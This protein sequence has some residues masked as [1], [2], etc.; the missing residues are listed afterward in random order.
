MYRKA[1]IRALTGIA[2]CRN[3]FKM[4]PDAM[5]DINTIVQQAKEYLLYAYTGG[6][7]L[8][9]PVIETTSS[10]CSRADQ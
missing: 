3:L 9:Q 1:G 8:I 2:T 4:G 6:A 7:T 10:Y 5:T